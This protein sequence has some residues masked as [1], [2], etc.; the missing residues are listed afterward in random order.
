MENKRK[1]KVT[2]EELGKLR[3]LNNNHV[4]LKNKMAD[5]EI[6]SQEIAIEKIRVFQN[7]RGNNSKFGEIQKELLSKY[8]N[9]SI[10]IDT[11]VIEEREPPQEKENK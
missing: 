2:K 3:E 11:G 7:I 5:L 4:S 6:S 8:G 10:N 1:R 9:V